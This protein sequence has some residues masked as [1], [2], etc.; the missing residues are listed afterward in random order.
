[1][2]KLSLLLMN[3]NKIISAGETIKRSRHGMTFLESRYTGA[4][5]VIHSAVTPFP[6]IMY[7]A[8]SIP[9]MAHAIT[10]MITQLVYSEYSNHE[11]A[12]S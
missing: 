5:N 2:Q 1:M 9:L 8:L 6:N 11:S 7:T 4:L 3:K 10:I 12:N